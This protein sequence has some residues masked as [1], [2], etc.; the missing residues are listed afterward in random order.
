MGLG[1]VLKGRGG[2]EGRGRE[3]LS[4]RHREPRHPSSPAP[5]HELHWSVRGSHGSA[6]GRII[7][8]AVERREDLTT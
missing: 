5:P 6:K 2:E 4:H 7:W 1:W 8:A 3:K